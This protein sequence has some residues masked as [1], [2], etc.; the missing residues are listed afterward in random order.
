MSYDSQT[1]DAVQAM[2]SSSDYSSLFSVVL[3]K[4]PPPSPTFQTMQDAVSAA[5]SPSPRPPVSYLDKMKP[6]FPPSPF[7]PS[8]P[9]F[10]HLASTAAAQSETLRAQAEEYI[11]RIINEKTVEVEKA[12][13]ELKEQVEALW[14]KFKTTVDKIRKEKEK[15]KAS[16]SPFTGRANPETIT[17]NSRGAPVAIKEFVPVPVS[18]AR[19]LSPSEAPRV[20]AL[21]ASLATSSFH[22]PRAISES[23]ASSQETNGSIQSRS[24]NSSDPATLVRSPLHENGT[25]VLQFPRNVDDNL[26]T[27][28]SFKYF[29]DLEQEIERKKKERLEEANRKHQV[30]QSRTGPSQL[31]SSSV[32]DG[33]KQEMLREFSETQS[34]IEKQ[35]SQPS[36]LSTG[37]SATDPTFKG[38]QRA[39]ELG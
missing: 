39:I 13:E 22:H 37:S 18:P 8:H 35:E 33:K 38:K 11:A 26:N 19:T 2:E 10:Q 1:D 4:L 3:P 34:A 31:S 6:L 15:L 36:E 32:T 17:D 12:E 24:S 29:I 16:A 9:V 30:E 25:N 28:V 27:A 5:R 20:S 21:S 7:T 14:L 23:H